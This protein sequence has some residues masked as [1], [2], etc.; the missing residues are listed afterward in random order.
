M[1]VKSEYEI[2]R[3]AREKEQDKEAPKKV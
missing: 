2:A 3:E 1:K